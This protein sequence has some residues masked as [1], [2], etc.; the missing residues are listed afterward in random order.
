MRWPADDLRRVKGETLS[1]PVLVQAKVRITVVDPPMPVAGISLQHDVEGRSG[2]SIDTWPC[3]SRTL[4]G[5]TNFAANT[6]RPVLFTSEHSRFAER[7][8]GQ[9]ILTSA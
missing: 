3:L 5:S 1:D 4:H 7:R 2:P 6:H 9:I 8:L